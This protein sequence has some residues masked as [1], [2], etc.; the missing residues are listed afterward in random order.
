MKSK[1]KRRYP[2]DQYPIY[3]DTFDRKRV[4]S[5]ILNSKS[6]VDIH[7]VLLDKRNI[8][9]LI[10]E[11]RGNDEGRHY[12]P[13]ERAKLAA[14]P[15]IEAELKELE[16]AYKRASQKSV[17]E[18]RPPLEDWP[19]ELL[20]KKHRREAEFDVITEEVEALENALKE[21]V[22]E[23]Q[24]TDDNLMLKYGPA[25]SG[26][27]RNGFLVRI[28]GQRVEPNENGV[29]IIDDDCSPYD[30]LSSVDYYTLVVKPWN[31]AKLRF[32]NE[33]YKIFRGD[34]KNP[35]YRAAW[36]K[37]L[38]ELHNKYPDWQDLFVKLLPG[39]PAMPIYPKNCKNH[40]GSA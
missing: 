23:Q 18:G 20:K 1:S 26:N 33:R 10:L 14:L 34:V 25:G 16:K 36:K 27:L 30:G 9:G 19:P 12:K 32:D 5:P 4:N 15:S 29:L 31:K 2:V 13:G 11:K 24:K 17:N 3:S 8:E 38:E 22:D 21:F 39:K 37:R 28:D 35:E 6:T 40:K 7:T